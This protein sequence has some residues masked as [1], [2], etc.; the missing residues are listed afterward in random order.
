MN[1]ARQPVRV[2]DRHAGR[3]TFC[4]ST[5]GRFAGVL[6]GLM[7]IIAFSLDQYFPYS[8]ISLIQRFDVIGRLNKLVSFF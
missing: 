8:L 4:A 1:V 5:D 3:Q 7:S 6:G 2:I